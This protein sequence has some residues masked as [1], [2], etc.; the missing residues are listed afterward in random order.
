MV[1]EPAFLSYSKRLKLLSMQISSLSL[2][3]G[4]FVFL[5]D[6]YFLRNQLIITKGE[7]LSPLLLVKRDQGT[8]HL[9]ALAQTLTP[10]N[11]ITQ[12]LR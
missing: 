4:Q 1:L 10:D 5:R 11:S 6:I 8:G 12:Q 2:I 7:D 9:N 3:T